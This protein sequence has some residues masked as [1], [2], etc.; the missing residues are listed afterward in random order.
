MPAVATGSMKLVPGGRPD[1][2]TFVFKDGTNI[3]PG[4]THMQS[5]VITLDGLDHHLEDWTSVDGKGALA[6]LRLDFERSR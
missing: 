4:D 6:T 3:R 1:Q 2:L 5:V